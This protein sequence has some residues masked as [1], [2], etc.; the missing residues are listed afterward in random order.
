MGD[1]LGGVPSAVSGSV[2]ADREHG[3]NLRWKKQR[4]R[5]AGNAPGSR[6]RLTPDKA[7]R[8]FRCRGIGSRR[9][10]KTSRYRQGSDG[11]RR[12]AT[13]GQRGNRGRLEIRRPGSGHGAGD[14][15]PIQKG[16]VLQE[17]GN[18]AGIWSS[19]GADE[20]SGDGS[21]SRTSGCSR[22]RAMASREVISPARNRCTHRRTTNDCSF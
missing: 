2:P 8:Y 17:A 4:K 18:M 11:I 13:S 21:S 5:R 9:R 7:D 10:R 3:R 19:Y 12:H 6:P 14:R 15:F 22:I 16:W 1:G 20:G